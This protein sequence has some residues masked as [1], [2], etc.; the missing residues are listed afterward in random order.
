MKADLQVARTYGNAFFQAAK[1][2]N[3]VV[4]MMEEAASLLASINAV[5]RVRPLLEAPH[6]PTEDKAAFAKKAFGGRVNPLLLNFVLLLLKKN[7]IEVLEEAFRHFRALS[8][9]DQ[10]ISRGVVRTAVALTEDQ[11][12]ALKAALEK[13]T[14][15][16]LIIDFVVDASV[17]GGV[18]F[19]AGDLLIDGSIS[20]GLERLRSTLM[21]ARIN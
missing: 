14:G 6:I 9:K 7:R 3:L 18:Q 15:L 4:Q 8:E 17:I 12:S 5:P 19:K 2:Q 16:R 20:G 1:G 13:S 10:G 21:A 11:K